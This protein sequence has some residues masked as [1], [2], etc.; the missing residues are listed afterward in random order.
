MDAMD[1]DTPIAHPI[2]I[3]DAFAKYADDRPG[4]AL[5]FYEA[6]GRL[7][8]LWDQLSQ[9]KLEIAL[10]EAQANLPANALEHYGVN[11]EREPVNE[12]ILNATLK[13]AENECLEART[14]YTLK[15]SVVEDALLADPI[16]RAV[17]S[18]PNAVPTEKYF[19]PSGMCVD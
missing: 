1:M 3:A 2:A 12:E 14:T 9:L 5:P 4:D 18:G 16:L 10:M 11:G 8:A 7:I 13:K 19:L 6:E 15:Q 17:H